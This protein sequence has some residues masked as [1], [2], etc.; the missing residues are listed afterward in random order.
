MYERCKKLLDSIKKDVSKPVDT[1]QHE[2]AFTPTAESPRPTYSVP[3]APKRQAAAT[4]SAS[5]TVVVSVNIC[6]IFVFNFAWST[7]TRS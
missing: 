5:P 3:P 6:K 4:T 7:F 2:G 1:L